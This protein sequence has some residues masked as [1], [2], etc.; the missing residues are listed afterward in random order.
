MHCCG[1]ESTTGIIPWSC[2]AFNCSQFN[3]KRWRYGSAS[4]V[5]VTASLETKWCK[6]VHY[7]Q[8]WDITR[9][10]MVTDRLIP[11]R[12]KSFTEREVDPTGLFDSLA[13][14]KHPIASSVRPANWKHFPGEDVPGQDCQAHLPCG[15][16]T[17]AQSGAV[18]VVY[19]GTSVYMAMALLDW[20]LATV[21]SGWNI[22][23]DIQSMVKPAANQQFPASM[24]TFT[25]RFAWLS[26]IFCVE[27]RFRCLRWLP[28]CRKQF[29]LRSKNIF[30]KSVWHLLTRESS[31]NSWQQR[32]QSVAW[33]AAA[34]FIHLASK[35]APKFHNL[36]SRLGFCKSLCIC[37][38]A[39][40]TCRLN[41]ISFL[42]GVPK[43][44]C[45]T[46][47]QPGGRTSASKTSDA[48]AMPGLTGLN[49]KKQK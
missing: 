21:E 30:Y 20:L 44:P 36:N 26:W 41:C 13:L 49:L 17:K 25:K 14:R 47:Q 29:S 45:Q 22:F 4:S 18:V 27:E 42:T 40:K 46:P 38:Y 34:F 43:L 28:F 23:K 3:S 16:D 33:G 32:S 31:C 1:K 35:T 24:H 15:L 6:Q 9:C 7:W 48:I 2:T 11:V 37:Y 8:P 19:R 10:L 5:K 39:P 12:K